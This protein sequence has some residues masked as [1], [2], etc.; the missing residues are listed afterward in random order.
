MSMTTK[1]A[2]LE[3]QLRGEKERA[4]RLHKEILHE[5]ECKAIAEKSAKEALQH[6]G[7]LKQRLNAAEMENQRLRGY[8]ARVQEDDVVREE[9]VATGDPDGERTMVPKRKPTIFERPRDYTD[10]HERNTMG[11]TYSGSRDRPK[12]KH[13]INY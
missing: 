11:M 3:S 6:F 5:R 4:D 12:P 10:F 13:W 1:T 8:L 7:D 9:L 2:A